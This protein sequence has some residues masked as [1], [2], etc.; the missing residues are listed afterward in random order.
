MPPVI[1]SFLEEPDK[2]EFFAF[3]HTVSCLT[4]LGQLQLIRSFS[5]HHSIPSAQQLN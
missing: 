4:A 3:T 5:A 2:Q 1:I